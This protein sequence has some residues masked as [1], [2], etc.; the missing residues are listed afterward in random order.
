MV[1]A[2]VLPL[3]GANVQLEAV[4]VA[5][6]AARTV[7]RFAEGTPLE[8]RR[9]PSPARREPAET[10]R[11]FRYLGRA[12]T[13]LTAF[14]TD[15]RT[16]A[17]PRWTLRAWGRELLIETR[18]RLDLPVSRT[19][20]EKELLN[21]LELLLLQISRLGSG[22]PDLEWQLARESMEWKHTLPRLRAVSATDGL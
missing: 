15:Q 12:E 22:V 14:R 11:P 4:A 18:M 6:E 3:T 13:L 5:E 7:V 8:P 1:A 2:S 17:S 16:P 10:T 19:P 20:E 9:R 21:D